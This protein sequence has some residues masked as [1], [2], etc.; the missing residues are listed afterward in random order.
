MKISY[1]DLPDP[2]FTV[3]VRGQADEMLSP[4]Q[5]QRPTP[6]CFVPTGSHRE[7]VFLR[8]SQGAGEGKRDESL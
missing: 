4:V 8:E 5:S 2:I 3:E 7:V 1:K 6:Q